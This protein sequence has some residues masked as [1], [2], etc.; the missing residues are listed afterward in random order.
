MTPRMTDRELIEARMPVKGCDERLTLDL[1]GAVFWEGEEV[2]RIGQDE[3]AVSAARAIAWECDH[4][5]LVAAATPMK[6][7]L[8]RLRTLIDLADGLETPRAALFMHPSMAGMKWGVD[9][10]TAVHAD[11]IELQFRQ[12]E[13]K[14]A[15][16]WRP[17][18]PTCASHL[19]ANSSAAEHA[20]H[21]VEVLHNWA[22]QY[23]GASSDA[24]TDATRALLMAAIKR[25]F[26]RLAFACRDFLAERLFSRGHAN[27]NRP[28]Q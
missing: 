1:F 17:E 6:D 16:L 5:D 18:H 4:L 28:R 3:D 15:Q 22:A 8:N 7:R 23:F 9:V 25:D 2:D 19:V 14:Y 24:Y 21:R 26:G 12:L 10:I 13:F 20:L 11:E 27:L